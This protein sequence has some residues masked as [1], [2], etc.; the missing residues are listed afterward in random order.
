VPLTCFAGSDEG[1]EVFGSQIVEIIENCEGFMVTEDIDEASEAVC[2]VFECLAGSSRE[3]NL[4][5]CQ[6]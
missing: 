3:P 1:G 6:Q 5:P 2:L 4:Y